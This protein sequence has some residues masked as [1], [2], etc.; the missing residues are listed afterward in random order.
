MTNELKF[1]RQIADSSQYHFIVDDVTDTTS[2]ANYIC[3]FLNSNSGG[4][5]YIPLETGFPEFSDPT[6]QLNHYKGLCDSV[7][8]MID[9]PTLY[10]MSV[11][12]S[13]SGKAL[14]IDVPA[15][16]DKPYLSNGTFWVNDNRKIRAANRSDL[17]DI[18]DASMRLKGRWERRNSLIEETEIDF[19]RIE[20][21][22][23]IGEK[24]GRLNLDSDTHTPLEVL[25]ELSYWSYSGFSNAGAILFGKHPQRRFPQIRTQI[26]VVQDKK[27]NDELV[28]DWYEGSI[29]AIAEQMFQRLTAINV[30]K[31]RFNGNS[32][33]RTDIPKYD[34]FALRE[35][36]V[37]A[38]V[39]REYEFFA[40]GLMVTVYSNRIEFWNAGTLNKNISIEE[41]SLN[42]QSFPNNP[43]IAHAFFLNNYM[44]RIGRGTQKIVESCE[45]LGAPRPEWK[46]DH[47]GVTLTIYASFS[48]D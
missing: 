28:S 47:S 37:N 29:L 7:R 39:H 24:S 33:D 1:E 46:Q 35:A 40:S 16:P 2:I 12:A 19:S 23:T 13:E 45:R 30:T 38:I 27:T 3:A 44:E 14:V 6:S 48:E 15:G 8:A 42:H 5:I 4:N 11:K 9:P 34:P 41:L 10:S 32:L 22:R 20:K 36:L 17:N 43:D 18:I 31:S 21:L 25:R 26:T